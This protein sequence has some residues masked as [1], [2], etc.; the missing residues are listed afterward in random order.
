MN[1][2]VL[3]LL[4]LLGTLAGQLIQFRLVGIEIALL[5]LVAIV[6][7][8]AFIIKLVRYPDFRSFLVTSP[9]RYLVIWVGLLSLSLVS[10]LPT[11]SLSA[12]E[13]IIALLYLGRLIAYLSIWPLASWKKTFKSEELVIWICW[14]GVLMVIL[15]I[16]QMAIFPDFQIY[17]HFGWDPHKHRLIATFLDPNFT[18]IWLTI[19]FALSSCMLMSRMHRSSTALL[20]ITSVCSVLGIFLT[21]SRSGLIALVITCLG[22]AAIYLN[23]KAFWF[24]AGLALLISTL[25]PISQRL[26]GIINLDTT[27]RYRLESW[28][29][30]LNIVSQYPLLGVGFNTLKFTRY[31]NALPGTSKVVS[32]FE[33]G[34]I[35]PAQ[36]SNRADAG[37]D[38]SLL[39]LLATSGIAGLL[40]FLWMVWNMIST[41][42]SRQ[43]FSKSPYASA[44]ITSTCGLFVSSWFVNAWLY[45][46]I[47][48]TWLLLFS[49]TY[50]E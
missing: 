18:A 30:A 46:P 48:V 36:L 20:W 6:L 10:I 17:D 23:R 7:L 1:S 9:L 31:D 32:R 21:V 43:F 14:T 37:F 22:L 13:I 47:L 24:L 35:R 49:L 8:G 33:D 29:G 50:D 41:N 45:P 40:A 15:G 5:D 34:I 25:S 44:F 42:W 26:N 4:V 39:T 16:T 3:I 11:L 27:S 19:V 2:K 28:E 38:S 12:S